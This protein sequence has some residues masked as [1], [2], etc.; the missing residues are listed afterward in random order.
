M[1]GN[2]SSALESW[3]GFDQLLVTG[4]QLTQFADA[5]K[6]QGYPKPWLTNCVSK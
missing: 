4:S 2:Q 6:P 1:D 3:P 5:S